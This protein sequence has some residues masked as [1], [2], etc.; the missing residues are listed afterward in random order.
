MNSDGLVIPVAELDKLNDGC[1][2]SGCFMVAIMKIEC[3]LRYNFLV[4]LAMKLK[5]G[6]LEFSL[7]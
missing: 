7:M 5:L 4:L 6:K 2:F 3:S 1:I